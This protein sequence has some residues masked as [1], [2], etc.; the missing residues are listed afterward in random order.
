MEH[1]ETQRKKVETQQK[2]EQLSQNHVLVATLIAT[3]AFAAGFTLPGGYKNDG[4]NEGM[5]TL[6]KKAAFTAFMVFNTLALLLSTYAVF[7]HFW[8]IFLS[9]SLSKEYDLISVVRP[10]LA[11]TFFAILAM[12]AAFISGTYTVLSHLPALAIPLCLLGCIFYILCIYF[13]QSAYRR[14]V[15]DGHRHFITFVFSNIFSA[16]VSRSYTN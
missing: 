8:S 9:T 10:T 4:S 15:N 5:A 6:A 2:L 14:L 12:V 13:L 16:D 1:E 11:C 7:L 3:V